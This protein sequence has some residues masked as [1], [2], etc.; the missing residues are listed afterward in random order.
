M[1][2]PTPRDPLFVLRVESEIVEARKRCAKILNQ[3]L[4]CAHCPLTGICEKR[5]SCLQSADNMIIPQIL[6]I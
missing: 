2:P 3:F 5:E 4:N 6:R 1:N